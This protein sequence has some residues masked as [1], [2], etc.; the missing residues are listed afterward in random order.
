MCYMLVLT[1]FRVVFF[2]FC[3]YNEKFWDTLEYF[4]ILWNTLEY[5]GIWKIPK[6]HVSHTKVFQS[7]PWNTPRPVFP[8]RVVVT[9]AE[10][11]KSCSRYI[12]SLPNL[13]N[14]R[15]NT[16]VHGGS[17]GSIR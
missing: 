9:C 14:L 12:S 7:M 17:L 4:G 15:A 3:F 8:C 16:V 2:H 1:N 13:A 11:L 10:K 5:F 6:K